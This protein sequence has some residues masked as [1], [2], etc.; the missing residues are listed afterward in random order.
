MNFKKR[1]RYIGIDRNH[2]P[3]SSLL[4][5]S[6]F[7]AFGSQQAAAQNTQN[8]TAL[9]EVI[10]TGSLLATGRGSTSPVM[11]I[12]GESLIENPRPNL[13][14]FFAANVPQ[15]QLEDSNQS[16]TFRENRTRV[17]GVSLR[18][19]GAHNTLTLI[20]GQRMVDYAE[21]V[22]T[23]WRFVPI[24]QTIPSIALRRMEMVLDGGSAIY[25][26]DAVAGVVNLIPDYGFEGVKVNFSTQRYEDAFSKGN[27]V[28]SLLLGTRTDSTSW[29]TAVEWQRWDH[30]LQSDLGIFDPATAPVGATNQYRE[31]A[32]GTGVG[33]LGGAAA[34]K[35]L[36]D[37]LCGTLGY[38]SGTVTT[39]AGGPACGT[40][41]W[42]SGAAGANQ[43]VRQGNR[44]ALTFFTGVEHEFSERLKVKLSAGYNSTENTNPQDGL[45]TAVN[46]SPSSNL[47]VGMQ[48]PI[49]RTNPG[50]IENA[51]LDP[52]WANSGTNNGF[53][54]SPM[55]L[56]NPWDILNNELN[57]TSKRLAGSIEY[58]LNDIWTLKYNATISQSEVNRFERSL[59]ADRL[60][61]SLAGL[62][63]PGCSGTVAG[64]SGCE[65]F[66][67]FL[68]STRPGLGNSQQLLEWIQPLRHT[69]TWGELSVHQAILTGDSSAL[70]ELPAGPVGIAAGYERRMD[71][72]YTDHDALANTGGYQPQAGGVSADFPLPFGAKSRSNV[73]DAV[74]LELAIPVTDD[75]NVQAAVRTE[76]YSE[77][78]DFS[79][80]NP[81][82]GFNWQAND[83]L[84]VRGSWGTS[85]KAPTIEHTQQPR[86]LSTTFLTLGEVGRNSVDGPCPPPPGVVTGCFVAGGIG[87][88]R[89]IILLETS[90]NPQ[91]QPVEST[92]WSFGFDWDITDNLSMGMNYVDIKFEN[93][94]RNLRPYDQLLE[95]PECRSGF[96]PDG[97][98][99]ND[100][101]IASLRGQNIFTA[102]GGVSTFPGNP[103]GYRFPMYLPAQGNGSLCFELDELGRPLQGYQK[104]VNIAEQ[105]V[106]SVDLRLSWTLDTNWG[107]FNVSPNAAILLNWKERASPSL[108]AVDFVG[109]R[110]TFGG[111]YQEYRINMPIRWSRDAH[112]VIL[113]PRYLSKLDNFLSG[114]PEDDFI[115]YDFNYLWQFSN[116]I[117]FSVFANNIF[118][119]YPTMHQIANFGSGMYPRD[120]RIVGANFEMT[121]GF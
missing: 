95:L 76:D 26:T 29:I 88:T 51:R 103:A 53:F 1:T 73:V 49:P 30:I 57:S 116:T 7:A 41:N 44:N 20:D 101:P 85:F 32:P 47:A 78:A 59:I 24:D 56:N 46:T 70:F 55:N 110:P 65:W 22:S 25:G 23:G 21:S 82:I 120:G 3:V 80:T 5:V 58:G 31:F 115:Y 17:Q 15:H 12:G 107:Q 10:V 117:R 84:T 72:W 43:I 93:V 48:I 18:G 96:S 121:F 34:G 83:R 104:P 36:I 40:T 67:P 98:F 77:A 19:L 91:L 118:N 86:N 100:Y 94:I 81:K 61:K 16:N 99:P 111:G 114:L 39:A 45:S 37:P 50:V 87:N 66:N 90:A 62:G 69:R 4:L 8:N 60:R 28:G 2:R 79:T 71:S 52:N 105:H 102:W 64:A 109:F 42:A 14:G 6:A 63:G 74:F 33:G 108:P 113:T 97:L 27:D 35:R 68:N 119:Q 54:L 11:V 75:L 89:N 38:Q 112:T 13:S 92:N 9:E 106:K